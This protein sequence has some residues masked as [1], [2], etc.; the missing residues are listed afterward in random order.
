MLQAPQYIRIEAE[1]THTFLPLGKG[2]KMQTIVCWESKISR[3]VLLYIKAS[4]ISVPEES[5]ED[6]RFLR[7]TGFQHNCPGGRNMESLIF[8]HIHSAAT[9]DFSGKMAMF[10]NNIWLLLC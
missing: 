8:I 1:V 4:T 10:I 6:K 2:D 9:I 7:V 5:K 3:Q